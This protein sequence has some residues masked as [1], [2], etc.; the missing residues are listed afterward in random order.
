MVLLDNPGVLTRTQHVLHERMMGFIRRSVS[1]SDVILILVDV[2][3]APKDDLEMIQLPANWDGPSV[4]VVLNKMDLIDA[5]ELQGI[6]EWYVRNC[7]CE[8]VRKICR[9][10]F[11]RLVMM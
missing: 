6:A 1:E 2:S 11:V 10:D 8:K 3:D 4:G 9:N 5:T 7:R